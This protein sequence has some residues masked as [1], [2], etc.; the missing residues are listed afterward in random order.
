MDL[1][2]PD[3]LVRHNKY[4]PPFVWIGVEM[5]GDT[6]PLSDAQERLKA[7][8]AIAIARSHDDALYAVQYVERILAP[9]FALYRQQGAW[10]SVETR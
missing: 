2:I 1:G 9:I 4:Y 10:L 8:R 6:T 3:L 5:K 7:L